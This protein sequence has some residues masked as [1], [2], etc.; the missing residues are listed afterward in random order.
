MPNKLYKFVPGMVYSATITVTKI[1]LDDLHFWRGI[2]CS[3][4]QTK[5]DITDTYPR[6]VFVLC[7]SALQFSCRLKSSTLAI[8]QLDEFALM[9]EKGTTR[10]RALR[11]GGTVFSTEKGFPSSQVKLASK[12]NHMLQTHTHT[13]HIH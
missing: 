7:F 6:T 11:A 2:K 3:E 12:L 8:F 5:E 9:D 1:I 10:D 4:L 13:H